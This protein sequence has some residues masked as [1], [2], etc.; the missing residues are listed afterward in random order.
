MKSKIIDCPRCLGKG[1]V[2]K[3]D[4]KRLRREFYWIEGPHCAYCD[5]MKYVSFDFACKVNADEWFLCSDGNKEEMQKFINEDELIISSVRQTEQFINY[6]G[7]YLMDNYIN[8][9][10][11][12]EQIIKQLS[13]DL[14]FPYSEIKPFIQEMI[15]KIKTNILYNKE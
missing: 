3:Q 11:N 15:H 4:I 7:K 13:M 9:G 10:I 2:D 12:K 14:K 5:G 8:K 1:Y 6:V